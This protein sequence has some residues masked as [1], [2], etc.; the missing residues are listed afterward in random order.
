M[1]KLSQSKQAGQ[2]TIAYKAE[3]SSAHVFNVFRVIWAVYKS[4]L[5]CLLFTKWCTIELL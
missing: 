3:R 4:C 1:L 2:L 5:H